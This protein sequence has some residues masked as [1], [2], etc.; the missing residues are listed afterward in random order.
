M[1]QILL[2]GDVLLGDARILVPGGAAVN[3]T[4]EGQ[5]VEVIE[6]LGSGVQREPED[7]SGTAARVPNCR[8]ALA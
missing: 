6:Q 7:I 5:I 4:G 1:A 8:S 3:P 2:L